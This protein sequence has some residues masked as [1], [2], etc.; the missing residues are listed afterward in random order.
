MI[1][2]NGIGGTELD[3]SIYCK[4]YIDNQK[5]R[6]NSATSYKTKKRITWIELNKSPPDIIK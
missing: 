4:K 3:L 6:M 2:I 1:D 5:T